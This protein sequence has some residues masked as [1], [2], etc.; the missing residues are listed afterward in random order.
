[1]CAC[2]F[3]CVCVCVCVFES[4]GKQASNGI[5]MR[6]TSK[7]FKDSQPYIREYSATTTPY[8]CL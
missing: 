8:T 5:D 4:V 1:M 2:V 6:E 7:S 3:V